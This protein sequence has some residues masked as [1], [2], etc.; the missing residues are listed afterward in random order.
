MAKAKARSPRGR[1]EAVSPLSQ[2]WTLYKPEKLAEKLNLSVKIVDKALEETGF[3]KAV[4]IREQLIK[5]KC[6][7]LKEQR[8]LRKG[9]SK[10]LKL[11]AAMRLTKHQNELQ[12]MNIRSILRISREKPR[13]NK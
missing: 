3:N 1:G 9:E 5:W 13:K 7:L 4:R 6:G 12:L 8:D 10:L 11:L 2:N